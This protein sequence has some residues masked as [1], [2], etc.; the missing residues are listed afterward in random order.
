M[1]LELKPGSLKVKFKVATSPLHFI[2]NNKFYE[3]HYFPKQKL[4]AQ[5]EWHP[6]AFA[7]LSSLF[8]LREFSWI[9]RSLAL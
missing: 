9:L 6:F 4:N 5:K 3:N 2:I 8:G 7:Q 1:I